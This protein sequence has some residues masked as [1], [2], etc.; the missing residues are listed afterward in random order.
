MLGRRLARISKTLRWIRSEVSTLPIFDGLFDIKI[1][2]Q[3]YEAQLP[4]FER[5]QHL[6]VALRATLARW[7]TTHQQNI[8]TWDTCRML[9]LIRFGVDVGRMELLYDG[10]SGLVLHIQAY[11]EEWNDRSKDEW[12]HLFVH[13]LDSSPR[14]W[15]VE[16][17]LQ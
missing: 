6:V 5:L 13:T 14:Y 7:W 2:V 8:A 11:E 15:Y 3:E 10:V 12:V 17:E 4:C 16:T 9:L 1:V